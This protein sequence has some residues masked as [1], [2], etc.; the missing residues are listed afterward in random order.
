MPKAMSRLAAVERTDARKNTACD[1]FGV[2]GLRIGHAMGADRHLV[3]TRRYIM[4]AR[5]GVGGQEASLR[6]ELRGCFNGVPR[7]KVVGV[8]DVVALNTA[9]MAKAARRAEKAWLKEIS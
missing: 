6:A 7:P 9:R 3:T 2:A 4:K 1:T 8:S 5:S